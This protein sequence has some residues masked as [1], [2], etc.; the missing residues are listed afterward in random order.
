[1]TAE[2]EQPSAWILERLRERWREHESLTDF[3]ERLFDEPPTIQ[4]PRR[5]R[6]CGLDLP[7][8]VIG[9]SEIADQVEHARGLP[10]RLDPDHCD[11]CSP[12]EAEA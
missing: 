1:M 3:N 2:V 8:F 7:A 12:A 6:G 10:D 9:W 11:T 4:I 5:C